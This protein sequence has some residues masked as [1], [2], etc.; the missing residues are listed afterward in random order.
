MNKDQH[1]LFTDREEAIYLFEK[2]LNEQNTDDPWPLLPILSLVGPA[3]YGKSRFIRQLGLYHCGTPPHPHTSLDFSRSG[4][5]HDLLNILGRLRNKLQRQRDEQGHLLKF[6]RFNILYAR[7]KRSEGPRE[8]EGEDA[9]LSDLSDLIGLVGNVNFI[10]GLFLLILKLLAKIPLVHT[11]VRL[12]VAWGYGLA[13]DRPK[14]HWYRDQVRK[15]KEFNLPDQGDL[16][17][18]TIL[19]RINEMCLGEYERDFL[20]EHIL[21]KAFL[22]DLRYGSSDK[23]PWQRNGS[24]QRKQGPR[25]VVIFLDSF[26]VLLRNAELTARSLLEALALNEYRKRG[27]SDPLLLVISSEVPLPDM[28][29]DQL[30]QHFLPSPDTDTR[31]IQERTEDLFNT[32]QQ[33][34][35]SRDNQHRLELEHVYLPLPF[36]PLSLDATREYLLKLDKHDGTHY[37][38]DESL[39]EDLHRETQGYPVFLERVAVALRKNNLST[40]EDLFTSGGRGE[41]IVDRLLA[42]HC[43]QVPEQELMLCAIP[44][45]LTPELLG[46]ILQL[47]DAEARLR[48][49]RYSDLPFLR[50][51]KDQQRMTFLPGVRALFL[52]K[53]QLTIAHSNTSEYDRVHR[54]LRDYFNDRI[55]QTGAQNEENLLE[56]SYHSLALGDYEAVVALACTQRQKPDR[57]MNLFK[58]VE[59]SPTQKLSRV[60]VEQRA[61]E[62]LNQARLHTDTKEVVGTIVLYTWLLAVPGSD[63]SLWLRL[64]TAYRYLQK[65]DSGIQRDMAAYCNQRAKDL[66]TDP[67]QLFLMRKTTE[68]LTEDAQA[69]PPK[70]PLKQRVA[71]FSRGLYRGV[72]SSRRTQSVLA[73]LLAFIVVTWLIVLPFLAQLSLRPVPPSTDNPFKLPLAELQPD[74]HNQWIGTTVDSDKEYI[75]L[76]DGTIPFDY[77]RPDGSLKGQAASKLRSGDLTAAH[78]LYMQALQGDIN[79]AEASIYLENTQ[80]RMSGKTCNIIFVIA[81]RITEDGGEGVNNGRD[82]LQG[83]Y[84]AQKEYNDTHPGTPICLY[85]ANMGND[86][87]TVAQ[88]IIKAAAANKAIQGLIGWPGLLDTPVSLQAVNQLQAVP[89]PIVSPDGYDEVQYVSNVFHVS[90]SYQDQGR[91]S[92]LYAENTLF[93]GNPLAIHALVI[94]DPTDPYSRCLTEGFRGRFE[95]DGNQIVGV[96]TY[97]TGQ[98]KAKT[99]ADNLHSALAVNPDF[100]YFAGGPMEG[101]V[102]LAQ[103]H[104]ELSS[105][106]L[107]GGNELYSFVGFSANTRAD[108]K[109]L[110]FTSPAYPDTPTAEHMT[111]LYAAAFDAHDP[112]NVREYGYSRPDDQAILS[113]D[114][115]KTLVT[116]YGNAAGL[117]SLQQA[118]SSVSVDGASRP[119]IT[120]TSWNELTDQ[121]LFMLFVDQQ[122]RINYKVI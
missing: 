118:L 102:L 96:Q 3:G 107:L 27:E 66:R 108:F 85:V 35:P 55:R 90:P 17:V 69:S 28:S 115:M 97:S 18:S 57:L 114:A 22:A 122:K 49:H 44:R 51:S 31:T 14:W 109:Q 15:F 7:L 10:L 4:D 19:R 25:R 119:L 106:P 76:S 113:Y 33:Q 60:N 87:A 99:L 72:L 2:Q 61:E 9:E 82:N 59:Q 38:T 86:P 116:A 80:I 26:E 120:F 5:R 23:E 34:V 94:T 73:G 12:L 30:S 70:V 92:A 64:E 75:G 1:D 79:D 74:S 77:M 11:L 58:V 83:A 54:L 67:V 36:S 41:Q 39:I 71:E 91:R 62:T 117:Q 111:A 63:P 52:R 43:M 68:P 112:G 121:R 78:D 89:I 56:F 93:A 13:G 42:T 45:T 32:W 20:I 100:I 104:A 6:P 84:V 8:E 110:A 98:T 29:S 53:L 95:G 21:A 88:Q 37:F 50:T 16:P 103:L 24:S 46:H 101:Q 105:L 48:W 81:T 47:S 65:A 40:V